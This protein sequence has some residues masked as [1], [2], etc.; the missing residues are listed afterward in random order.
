MFFLFTGRT[1]RRH[2]VSA[3]PGIKWF[4]NF[5]F[6]Q[7]FYSTLKIH[8]KI[9]FSVHE[10]K[11]SNKEWH[12]YETEQQDVAT[13]SDA[14]SRNQ[15]NWDL[16]RCWRKIYL[17]LFWILCLATSFVWKR[18]SVQYGQKAK[19]CFDNL[20]SKYLFLKLLDS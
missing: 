19:I 4:W 2:S 7:A 10:K 6:Q 3:N 15:L 18:V 5:R 9:P 16:S 14:S 20:I 11:W 13:F 17:Y 8:T 12:A 1:H